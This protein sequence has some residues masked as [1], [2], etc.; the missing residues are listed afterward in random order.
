M[1]FQRADATE[2]QLFLNQH[3]IVV[4]LSNRK[5]ISQLEAT[6]TSTNIRFITQ[7]LNGSVHG[8]TAILVIDKIRHFDI[9]NY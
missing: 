5:L 7:N 9:E 1:E 2:L 6:L 3:K 8:I 4:L